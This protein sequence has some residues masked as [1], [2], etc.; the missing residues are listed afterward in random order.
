[1]FDI[2]FCKKCK[3]CAKYCPSNSIPDG[4]RTA[5][6]WNLHNVE[7]M[8]RWPVKAMKC[9]DDWVKN[10]NHCSVCNRVCPWNKPNNMLHKFV[11]FFAENS[12]FPKVVVYLDQLLG[13][14]KQTKGEYP[15][16]NLE[17]ELLEKE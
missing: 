11:R 7:G 16:L 9:L 1:M 5:K 6:S 4:E 15:G 13:F 10:G 17:P 12:I 2:K 3:L 8:L 14:G